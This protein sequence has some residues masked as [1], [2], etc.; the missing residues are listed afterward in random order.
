MPIRKRKKYSRPKRIFDKIRIQDEN[1][2]IK[3][4]GLKSKR[5][6]WKAEAAIEKIRRQAKVLLTKTEQEQKKFINKLSQMGLK[7][8]NIAEILALNKEDYLK[9]RLQSILVDKK[10]ATTPK[11]A[12]QFIA[13]K[14]IA[15]DNKKINIPSYI[16]PLEDE[17]KISLTIAKKYPKDKKSIESEIRESENLIEDLGDKQN[18]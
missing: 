4:Y 11:Q 10:I 9:R 1:V 18:A 7:V 13:H 14:H 15:I 3:K 5:E 17:N 6:I 16:V 8:K 2:L 12:R